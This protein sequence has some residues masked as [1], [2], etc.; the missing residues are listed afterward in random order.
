MIISQFTF[1]FM[2]SDSENSWWKTEWHNLKAWN[3]NFVQFHLF[4]ILSK[5]YNKLGRMS[6]RSWNYLFGLKCAENGTN[7]KLIISNCIAELTLMTPTNL[8]LS[9]ADV[10]PLNC[11]YIFSSFYKKKT[12]VVPIL[13]QF[14][15]HD[16]F[17]SCKF[18]NVNLLNY[19]IDFTF[20]KVK[21]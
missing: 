20:H 5:W 14:I 13:K 16:M 17:T 12:F 19:L 6:C 8:I 9:I 7:C 10:S 2:V 15:Y 21:P 11:K 18:Y 4:C 3:K 1:T